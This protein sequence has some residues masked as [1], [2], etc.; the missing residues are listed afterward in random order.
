[1]K[2]LTKHITR[3]L[4]IYQ[5]ETA[6]P[7]GRKKPYVQET[8]SY[9]FR[10]PEQRGFCIENNL[11]FPQAFWMTDE[12]NNLDYDDNGSW[13]HGVYITKKGNGFGQGRHEIMLS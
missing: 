8:E 7:P 13:C 1:M 2:V 6:T 4:N 11:G 3:D 12:V 9:Q 5:W 10:Q